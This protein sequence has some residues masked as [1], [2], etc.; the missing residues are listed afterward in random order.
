MG[1][2]LDARAGG[3][4]GLVMVVEVDRDRDGAGAEASRVTGAGVVGGVGVCGVVIELVEAAFE[5]EERGEGK[6]PLWEGGGLR[7]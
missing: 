4:G 3:G 6:T 7:G 2:D 1:R 5:V